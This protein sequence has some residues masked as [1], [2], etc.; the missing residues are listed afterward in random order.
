MASYRCDFSSLA[1][2][3][4]ALPMASPTHGLKSQK[5]ACRSAAFVSTTQDRATLVS[6]G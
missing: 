1:A 6:T 3:L 4:Q 5:P 2:E